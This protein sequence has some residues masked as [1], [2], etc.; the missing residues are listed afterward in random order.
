[1]SNFIK[2]GVRHPLVH[3]EYIKGTPIKR[4]TKRKQRPTKT[5]NNT[6]NETPTLTLET[7]PI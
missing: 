2:K 7:H 4:K 6:H 3:D 5:Q 1:M